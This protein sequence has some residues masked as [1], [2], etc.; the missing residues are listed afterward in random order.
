MPKRRD[1]IKM[2]SEEIETFLHGR[3]TMTVATIGRD[4][5]PHLVAMWYGFLD[6]APVF[7]TYRKSQKVLNLQRDDRITCMIEDGDAYEELRGVELVGRGEVIEDPEVVMAA[8]RSVVQRYFGVPDDQIDGFA[9]ALA[10]KRVA[11][12]V[13]VDQVVSWDHSKL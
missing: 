8:A 2:S 12:K 6:G 13:H 1:Q 11:V 10:A 4:G 7:E 5:W 3:R 9:A